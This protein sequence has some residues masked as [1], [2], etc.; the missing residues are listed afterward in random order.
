MLLTFLKKSSWTLRL[1]RMMTSSLSCRTSHTISVHHDLLQFYVWKMEISHQL[2]FKGLRSA[3][4]LGLTRI[5]SCIM[6]SGW[7]GRTSLCLLFSCA[8]S[9]MTVQFTPEAWV[10]GN[11]Q[12]SCLIWEK[13]KCKCILKKR[14]CSRCLRRHRWQSWRCCLLQL[15]WA[16]TAA[17][18]GYSASNSQ[19]SA[20]KI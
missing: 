20:T 8:T 16:D 14:I 10:G 1:T 12:M 11:E 19:N 2:L 9:L 15:Q 3:C 6:S 4:F 5:S 13:W 7:S 17:A 18:P